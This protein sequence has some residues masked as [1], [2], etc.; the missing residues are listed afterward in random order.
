MI[1]SIG[2]D[3]DLDPRI[4]NSELW[5]RNRIRLKNNYGTTE[6][7]SGTLVVRVTNIIFYVHENIKD[8]KDKSLASTLGEQRA[9]SYLFIAKSLPCKKSKC[10]FVHFKNYTSTGSML[11]MPA[12]KGSKTL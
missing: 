11:P 12:I 3:A 8:F 4:S 1:F 9:N 7:G 5:I 2:P 6:S 10:V